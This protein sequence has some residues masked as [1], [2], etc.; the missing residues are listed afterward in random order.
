[1]WAD[2]IGQCCDVF[3]GFLLE[4]LELDGDIGTVSIATALGDH[5]ITDG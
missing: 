5:H 1:M 2:E 4:I 3:L